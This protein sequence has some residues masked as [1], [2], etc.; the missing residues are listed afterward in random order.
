[1]LSCCF[2]PTPFNLITAVA[3][4]E[5]LF[6]LESAVCSWQSFWQMIFLTG[7]ICPPF[8]SEGVSGRT[9]CSSLL[10]QCHPAGTS[11]CSFRQHYLLGKK[12]CSQLFFNFLIHPFFVQET[13]KKSARGWNSSQRILNV[14]WVK[15]LY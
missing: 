15:E 3:F 11:R 4:L 9:W 10:Q 7:Q 13:H 5:C 2:F 12:I 1:M 6:P 14:L 8:V